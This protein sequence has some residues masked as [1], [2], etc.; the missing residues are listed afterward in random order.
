MDEAKNWATQVID[1]RME[2]MIVD[3]LG[4]RIHVQRETTT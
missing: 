4:G 1:K 2:P 3:T